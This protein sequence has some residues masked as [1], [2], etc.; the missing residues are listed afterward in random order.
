MKFP[1]D[2]AARLRGFYEGRDVLV[3]GGA[4]FIGGHL[5]DALLSLGAT[6]TV[7]DDL[8]N[9]E[10]DH[11]SGLME[12]EPERVR[13]VKGSILDDEALESAMRGHEPVGMGVSRVGTPMTVFHL[14]AV[15]SVQ[16]SVE[17]PQRTWAVNATGTVRVLE[18]A[19]RA[20]ARRVVNF[21]SSSVYGDQPELPK[22][23]SQLPAPRSPY[24]A[25]KL[26]AEAAVAAWCAAYGSSAISLRCFNVFGPRQSADSRYAA[27]IPAFMARLAQNQPPT[28]QGDGQQS[29]DFTFVANAVAATLLA[30]SATRD[31]RGEAINV[32]TARR[33]TIQDLAREIA[34]RFGLSNVPWQYL[35]ARVGDVRH[36][37]A[38]L[39]RAK[40]LVGYEPFATLEQG[41][42]EVVAWFKQ[43]TGARA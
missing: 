14:A 29:R 28:I 3:T 8:S 33:V 37:L 39:S 18:A 42:D 32:G 27:V 12:I 26:A 11:L 21:S 15:G 22:R 13:F 25:S 5:V 2:M 24:A 31:L 41:L 16:R 7:L 36:S 43:S 19:R 9:S 4:G 40:E 17:D 1:A 6:I 34:S 35:P 10:L 23:E 20:G 38:D 30:G